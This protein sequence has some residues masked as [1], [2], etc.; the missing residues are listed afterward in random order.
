MK[1]EVQT[2]SEDL[3]QVEE[4]E[5]GWS[6]KLTADRLDRT[7]FARE[8]YALRLQGEFIREELG[9]PSSYEK[10][11]AEYVQCASFGDHT[12]SVAAR[13]GTDRDTGVPSYN[14]F[15]VGGESSFAGLAEGELR[16][17]KFS[18]A[19]L[20]YRYRLMRLSPSLGRGVYILTRGDAGNVWNDPDSIDY[21]DARYGVAAG[22]GADTAIGPMYIGYGMAD[23]GASRFYFSL[24]TIF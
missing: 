12:V 7:V 8:G 2:G 23:R 3:P 15:R 9:S 24:G 14:V 17:Q 19:T 13:A 5:A 18:V 1:A 6:V 16:G 10:L 11:F 4:H 22:L 21:R 20:A